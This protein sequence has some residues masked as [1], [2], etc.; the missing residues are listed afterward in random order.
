MTIVEKVNMRSVTSFKASF[1]SFLERIRNEEWDMNW[2]D[3]RCPQW[4]AYFMSCEEEISGV[5]FDDSM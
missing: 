5:V 1:E 2:D 3:W 4:C